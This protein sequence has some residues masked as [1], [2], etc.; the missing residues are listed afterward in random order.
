M[1]RQGKQWVSQ[2]AVIGFNSG[3]CNINM[4]KKYFAKDFS[5]DKE[6]EC[7]EDVF[8]AYKEKVYM[9]LNTPNFE[10]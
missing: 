2:V 6:R 8:A 3:K 7:N 9:F 1:R 5:Y 4:V 10:F